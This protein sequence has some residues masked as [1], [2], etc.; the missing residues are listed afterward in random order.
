MALIDT[1][2]IR[3]TVECVAAAVVVQARAAVAVSVAVVVVVAVLY[4]T[5]LALKTRLSEL[6]VSLRRHHPLP[7]LDDRSRILN[8]CNNIIR[9]LPCNKANFVGIVQPSAPANCAN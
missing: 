7:F 6:T 3:L 8:N 4:V 9:T 5:Q 1:L 2:Q